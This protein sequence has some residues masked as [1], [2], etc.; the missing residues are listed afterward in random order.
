M[1]DAPNPADQ[2]S[3]CARR[4]AEANARPE[5]R[6]RRRAGPSAVPRA[7][8]AAEWPQ[9]IPRSVCC[10]PTPPRERPHTT[11]P[12]CSA[13][14]AAELSGEAPLLRFRTFPHEET[15]A[16][17]SAHP[18]RA[19]RAVS[20]WGT[21]RLRQNRGPRSALKRAPNRSVWPSLRSFPTFAHRETAAAPS[22]HPTRALRAVSRWATAGFGWNCGW[23]DGAVLQA[24]MYAH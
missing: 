15:A 8:G 19:L 6:S 13:F 4:A 7:A 20:S 10:T 1:I 16:V 11:P 22:A 5:L 14:W 23:N 12:V 17:P 2:C 9:T 18:T 3:D 24:G 21:V